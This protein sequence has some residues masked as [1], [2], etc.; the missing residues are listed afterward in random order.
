MLGNIAHDAIS[1]VLAAFC[2]CWVIRHAN[3]DMDTPG[4]Y[5]PAEEQFCHSV[6]GANDRYG[7]H[8][9]QRPFGDDTHTGFAFSQ[10][11]VS[12]P[13]AFGKDQERAMLGS[14]DALLNGG[15]LRMV[16][17]HK[18]RCKLPIDPAK[19]RRRR[20][21][22]LRYVPYWFPHPNEAA[23][24]QVDVGKGQVIDGVDPRTCDVLPRH[25]RAIERAKQGRE[26]P[27]RGM[28]VGASPCPCG[29]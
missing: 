29:F 10:D 8:G 17:I 18:D 28:D 20:K 1:H 23:A 4:W 25:P 19:E 22:F 16:A 3:M 2:R 12:A 21:L 15:A 27:D 6:F 24:N 13:R 14:D 26:Q 11:A 5:E 9:H 7:D